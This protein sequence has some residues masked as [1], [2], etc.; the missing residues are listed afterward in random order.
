MKLTEHLRPAAI[1]AIRL[2]GFTDDEIDKMTMLG[3]MR[4]F[5]GWSLGD[6]AWGDDFYDI[7]LAFAKAGHTALD[8]GGRQD[9]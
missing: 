9:G 7:V 8:K 5:A 1:E 2:R 4:A 3:A 6:S